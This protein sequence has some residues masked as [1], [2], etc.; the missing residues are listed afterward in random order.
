MIPLLVRTCARFGISLPNC[1]EPLGTHERCRELLQEAGF[2][3][4]EIR[5][6]Q[7]G[8]YLRRNDVEWQ[9]NGDS[10]WI[11]PRG[12]PLLEL[13]S[14]RLREIRLAYESEVAA[15]TTEQGFWHE[16]TMFFVLAR[17]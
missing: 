15:L 9:W 3:K 13:S 17:K 1:N 11:D 10:N 5:T 12:N 8:S 16:I 4:I 6:R 14:E 7:F 2:D